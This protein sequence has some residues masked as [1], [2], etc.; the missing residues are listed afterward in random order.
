MLPE[1]LRGGSLPGN[2]RASVVSSGIF[3]MKYNLFI[4]YMYE[5]SSN[6][7]YQWVVE[8]K[9]LPLLRQST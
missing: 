3:S 6:L 4:F 1:H 9:Q 8:E 2:N 5:F 7:G